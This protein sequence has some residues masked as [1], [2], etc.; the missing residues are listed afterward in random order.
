MFIT[1][2]TDKLFSEKYFRFKKIVSEFFRKKMRFNNTLFFN[3][4]KIK[5]G[6]NSK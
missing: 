1:K 3:K 2:I 5:N 4:N 6:R